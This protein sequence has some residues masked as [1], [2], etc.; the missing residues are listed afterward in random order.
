MTSPG[1]ASPSST[2]WRGVVIWA[3]AALVIGALNEYALYVA[4]PAVREAFG[5]PVT[6]I[7]WMLLVFLIADAIVLIA[8]GRLGDRV[9][10]AKVAVTGL[11]LVAIGSLVCAVAPSFPVLLAGR[12]IEGI[13]VG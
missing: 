12:V 7:G 11:A 6:S 4:T 2:A 1:A 13:G 5:L 9:G 10:R 3:G 8:A